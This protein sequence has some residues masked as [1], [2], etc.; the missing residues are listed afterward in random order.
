M[1][2]LKDKLNAIS[3][4]AT[5]LTINDYS[6]LI[7]GTSCLAQ[8]SKSELKAIHRIQDSEEKLHQLAI[9]T[10]EK[11]SKS[12]DKDL[13]LKHIA[14]TG[15]AAS[16]AMLS[17]GASTPVIAVTALGVATLSMATL[18]ARK[19]GKYL[20]GKEFDVAQNIA[21]AVRLNNL[22][23]LQKIAKD[24]K[25]SISNWLKAAKKIMTEEF[26]ALKKPINTTHEKVDHVMGEVDNAKT[27]NAIDYMDKA[28]QIYELTGKVMNP[29]LAKKM[30]EA[31]VLKKSH[32]LSGKPIEGKVLAIDKVANKFLQD[33][34]AMGVIEHDLQLGIKIGQSVTVNYADNCDCKISTMPAKIS[35]DSIFTNIKKCAHFF[36][37]IAQSV[38]EKMEKV[39]ATTESKIMNV[40]QKTKS[41]FY[42]GSEAIEAAKVAYRET[43]AKHAELHQRNQTTNDVNEFSMKMG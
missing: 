1:K 42:A 21:Q 7:N 4:H 13:E 34:G 30:D 32:P 39:V 15:L 10:E 29:D 20:T 26:Q 37:K 9:K 43:K 19:I 41:T 36:A 38:S 16:V 33:C 24:D 14:V 27:E 2:T 31:A 18:G 35:T 40:Q 22:P 5:Q 3:E 23:A 12:I 28:S 6:D 8:L 11:L 25:P 17:L